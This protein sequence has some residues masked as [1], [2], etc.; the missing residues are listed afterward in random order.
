MLPA[1][2]QVCSLNSPFEADVADYAAGQCRALEVWLTKLETYLAKN[3]PDDVRRLLAENEM[4]A[5]V[6]AGQGGLLTSQGE[7]RQAAWDLFARRLELCQSLGIGTLVLACDVAGP[8]TQPDLDRARL[9]L[10]QAAQQAGLRG[11]RIAL[12]FQARSA[13]G[14]NLQTT[15]AL[16]AEV[17]SP[18]LGLCF[19]A[20]HYYVGPSKFEDLGYLTKANLFH[21]QLCDLAD[22]PREFA[23][24][25]DRILP[26][27]GEMLLGPIID[28]FREIGYAGHVSLELL[29]P[30]I[31]QVPARQFG[32]IGL[33]SLRKLLGQARM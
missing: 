16:V 20:F 12:E 4:S 22:V 23:T 29:N 10:V 19:D 27:D 33:T 3:S 1:L 24:D 14:N 6:A 7:A 32:E 31:W 15:A 11:L 9:S 18:H 8:L 26:G 2:S 30:Q 17:A 25:S 28:R 13:L 5:P 21:V